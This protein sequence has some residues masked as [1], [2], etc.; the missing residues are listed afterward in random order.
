M[1]TYPF[2]EI[3]LLYHKCVFDGVNKLIIVTPSASDISVKEDIYSAWKEW[4]LVESNGKFLPALRTTGGDPIGGGAY[5]GDVYFLING[6][7]LVIDHSCQINGSI[8]S[9]DYPSPYI[10]VTG[11]QIVINKVSSLVSTV[12]TGG[13][14]TAP[15]VQQIR[16]EMDDNSVK[17]AAILAKPD[18]A[19][20]I[21][22]RQE[23]DSNSTKLSTIAG[24]TATLSN[25]VAANANAQA[26][27]ALLTVEL[28]H[29]MALQNGEGLDSVQA[30]MLLEIY[31]LYGLDPTRPL[32]VTKTSRTAGEITQTI[33]GTTEQTTVTRA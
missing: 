33:T 30:T 4:A 15:T 11:T 25:G 32:L 5:T 28:N 26:T 20:P 1:T 10:S 13:S 21:Q 7:R 23:L 9:D 27:K 17:L 18:A 2:W 3:W 29:L 16:A 24:D 31:R 8:F 14:G 22:I 19:T 6:W 12:S